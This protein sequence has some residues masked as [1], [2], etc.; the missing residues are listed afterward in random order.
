MLCGGSIRQ[1]LGARSS[2]AASFGSVERLGASTIETT[3][4]GYRLVVSGGDVD[5]QQF[6]RLLRRARELLTLG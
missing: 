1:L 4:Q 5:A 6:E 2:K 3:T